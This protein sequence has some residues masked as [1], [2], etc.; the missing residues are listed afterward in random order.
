MLERV[1]G[2]VIPHL[3]GL[4]LLVGGWFLSITYVGLARF[5]TN[6]LFTNTTGAGLLMIIVGAYFPDIYIGIRDKFKK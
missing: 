6:V 4:I 1:K 2:A 5:E 3:I